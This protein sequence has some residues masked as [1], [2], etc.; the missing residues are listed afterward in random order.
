MTTLEAHVGRTLVE[1]ARSH[2]IKARSRIRAQASCT[3]PR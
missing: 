2:L 3:M 1:A